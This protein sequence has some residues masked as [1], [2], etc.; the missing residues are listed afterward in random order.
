MP[1]AS[2]LDIRHLLWEQKTPRKETC[3]TQWLILFLLAHLKVDSVN[4]THFL[5]KITCQYPPH[6]MSFI[7]L[8]SCLYCCCSPSQEHLFFM[9]CHK[10]IFS[11]LLELQLRYWIIVEPSL[12]FQFDSTYSSGVCQVLSEV[13]VVK[14]SRQPKSDL[15]SKGLHTLINKVFFGLLYHSITCISI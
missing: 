11:S 12:S 8:T 1:V 9:F 4:I 7:S 5:I 6:N 3:W 14:E 2:G 15:F 10:S 13:L